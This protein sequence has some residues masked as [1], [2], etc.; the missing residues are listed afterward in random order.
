VKHAVNGVGDLVSS[1][2]VGFLWTR[3]GPR[4]ALSY[5]GVLALVATVSLLVLTRPPGGTGVGGQAASQR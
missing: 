4:L 5:G 3:F 1:V 2:A